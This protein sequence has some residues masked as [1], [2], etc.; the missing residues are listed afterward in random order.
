MIGWLKASL[1]SLI[2][3]KS[4]SIGINVTHSQDTAVPFPYN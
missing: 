4:G 2:D 1:F 3:I